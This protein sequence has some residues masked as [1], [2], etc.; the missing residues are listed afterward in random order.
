MSDI[1]WLNYLF[2][3]DMSD[4]ADTLEHVPVGVLT[5]DNATL[6]AAVLSTHDT[7]EGRA[8]WTDKEASAWSLA[9]AEVVY[10][11][12]NNTSLPSN[13]RFSNVLILRFPEASTAPVGE[14][15]LN[16]NLS[17]VQSSEP[18]SE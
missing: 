17:T 10:N 11:G 8:L 18:V 15:V 6:L 9:G 3:V 2:F 5:A 14:I 4:E 13:G 7:G 16:Y 1:F 12:A